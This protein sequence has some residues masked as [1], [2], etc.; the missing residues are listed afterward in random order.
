MLHSWNHPRQLI[1]SKNLRCIRLVWYQ[2]YMRGEKSN[3]FLTETLQMDSYFLNK[4]TDYCP[5]KI[6]PGTPSNSQGSKIKGFCNLCL[7]K[8]RFQHLSSYVF[9]KEHVMST[10]VCL[11][12]QKTSCICYK[13]KHIHGAVMMRHLPP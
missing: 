10:F 2:L 6:D 1:I 3:L 11:L 4:N 9:D 7:K 5:R 8:L 12:T 13:S